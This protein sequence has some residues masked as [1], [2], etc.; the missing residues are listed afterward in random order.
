MPPPLDCPGTARGEHLLARGPVALI[1]KRRLPTQGGYEL[2]RKSRMV[3]PSL[4]G[5]V[6]LGPPV[7]IRGRK[8]LILVYQL[9][10][11]IEFDTIARASPVRVAGA[12][13]HYIR[14]CWRRD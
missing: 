4:L 1:K 9:G 13:P 11:F 8:G 14:S 7:R 3:A 10:C 6:V 12:F 5:L 2:L